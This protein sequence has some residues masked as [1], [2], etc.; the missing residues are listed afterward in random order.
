M[1]R[2]QDLDDHQ[3]SCIFRE[4]VCL[5]SNCEKQILFKDFIDHVASDHKDWDNEATKVDEKI[6]HFTWWSCQA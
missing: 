5:E 1:F 2:A 6:F 3:K 4:I